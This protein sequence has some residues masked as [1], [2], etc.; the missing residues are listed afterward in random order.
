MSLNH[1][2]KASKSLKFHALFPLFPSLFPNLLLTLHM[3]A[4]NL[5]LTLLKSPQKPRWRRI[6]VGKDVVEIAAVA[7]LSLIA[8]Q[9]RPTQMSRQMS[10]QRP[11]ETLVR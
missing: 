11:M 1:S 9:R 3:L 8:R 2:L 6:S 7:A 5:R 4:I 10:R